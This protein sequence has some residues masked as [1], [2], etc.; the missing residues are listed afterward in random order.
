[1]KSTGAYRITGGKGQT[2][3]E[4]ALALILI[5]V[6]LIGT[7]EFSR[8]WYRKTSFKNAVRQGARVA[9]VTPAANFSGSNTSFT[10][11]SA[12]TCPNTDPIINGVCC[13][14]GVPRGADDSASVTLTCTDTSN[15]PI[16]CSAI[17]TGGAIK[18]S[19]TYSN[20]YFFVIGGGIWPWPSGLSFTTD[21][22]MRYE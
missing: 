8:G 10:C 6:I 11:N 3:I 12:T 2:L 9:V 20:P 7:A 21:A 1:M 17:T 18:V 13:Q 15:S 16:S 14:P 19:A 5:L 4:T 22:T